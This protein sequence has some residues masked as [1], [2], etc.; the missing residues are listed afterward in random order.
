MAPTSLLKFGPSKNRLHTA[1]QSCDWSRRSERCLDDVSVV[2]T[3][4]DRRGFD[5]S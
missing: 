4:T 1:D 3:S 2:S 5:C